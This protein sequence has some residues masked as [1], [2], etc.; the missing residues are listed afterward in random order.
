MFF[1]WSSGESKTI[2][3]P[4]SDLT[5][6]SIIVLRGVPGETS[7]MK[8]MK[9]LS[10]SCAMIFLRGGGIYI[11]CGVPFWE[12]L[13]PIVGVLRRVLCNWEDF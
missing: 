3:P 4:K 11:Y 1:C 6:S 2:I 12:S 8:S 5:R 9:F 10:F 7:L 13:I